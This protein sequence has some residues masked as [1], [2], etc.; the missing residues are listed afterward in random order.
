MKWELTALIKKLER[1]GKIPDDMLDTM[2]ADPKF[3]SVSQ[4]RS[5]NKDLYDLEDVLL[6]RENQIIFGKGKK[7]DV[8]DQTIKE[9]KDEVKDVS[10]KMILEDFDV[11]GRKKNASGGIA[12]QL[13]LNEGGRVSFV[14]GGKVSSGLAKILGV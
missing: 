4:T 1:G 8:S 10:E 13:H 9:I 6:E 2:I 12:G 7:G 11:T 3:P 5:T 14:K